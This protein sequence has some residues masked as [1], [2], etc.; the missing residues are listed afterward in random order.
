MVDFLSY[1]HVDKRTP[2]PALLFFVKALIIQI[3]KNLL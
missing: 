1:I 2:I 3:L